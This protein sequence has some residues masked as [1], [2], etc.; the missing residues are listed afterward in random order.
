[1]KNMPVKYAVCKILP[2]RPTINM[3][4][5][6]AETFNGELWQRKFNIYICNKYCSILKSS[7]FISIELISYE[8]VHNLDSAIGKSEEKNLYYS[9]N[10][11]FFF[12]SFIS[13][14]S[15]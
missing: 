8:V 15:D 5:A 1:M 11:F 13:V 10:Y 2:W 3:I 4:H 12:Q 9:K 6:R 7:C 14:G